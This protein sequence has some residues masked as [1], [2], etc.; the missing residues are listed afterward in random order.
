M[1]VKARSLRPY[2]MFHKC[3]LSSGDSS[4]RNQRDSSQKAPSIYITPVCLNN[5]GRPLKELNIEYIY[6][7]KGDIPG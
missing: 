7:A 1:L 5:T 3:I 6:S 4:L 2:L